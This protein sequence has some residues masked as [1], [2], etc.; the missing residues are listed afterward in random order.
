MSTNI[1]LSQHHHELVESLVKSGRHQNAG[2]VVRDGRRL[3]E[4]A[5]ADEVARVAVLR[6]EAEQEWSDLAS[7]RFA[8]VNDESL[9]DLV[10]R[11]GVRAAGTSSAG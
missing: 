6:H 5:H 4:R 10:T 7:G 2:D 11:L 1:G 3:L 8:D 9:D